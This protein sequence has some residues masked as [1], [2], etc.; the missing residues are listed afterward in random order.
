MNST[1][2][3]RILIANRGEIA[4]RVVR[5]AR[6]RGLQSVAAYSEADAGALHVRLAD[7][8]VPIGPA[9]VAQSYLSIDA[10]LAAA[11]AS[12]ADAVHPGYGFLSENAE[13]A[14]ACR[15]ARLVFIGPSPEAI[16]AMGNKAAAKRRMLEAGM[17]CVPGYQGKEQDDATFAREAGRIGYP[18]MV[19][20][21]AGGG[22]RGMRLV[23]QSADL[24]Q[25]LAS[26]RSEAASAFGSDELIL[27]KA[28]L[29]PR[30]VEIQILAD[31]HGN[32]VHVGER[33]CSVQ[34]RH[35]KVLEEAPCPVMTETLR[36][37]MGRAAVEAARAI[38][39]EGA[40]TVEF[41]L[42][43]RGDFFFLEMNTRI[44]VEHPVTE[45]VSGLDLV[46]LQID[47]AQGKPLPF[48]QADIRLEGHAIE[49][50][51][52]A[53]DPAA[54]FLP[55]TGKILRW[56]PPS[57]PGIRVDH[58]LAEHAEI[59]PFYDPMIAKLIAYGATRDEARRRLIRA[60]DETVLF[61]VATNRGFLRAMLAHPAF[62]AGEATTAF[63]AEHFSRIEPMDDDRLAA[64]HAVAAVLLA[65]DGSFG[66]LSSWWSTGQA[67]SLIRLRRGADDRWVEV[68][69]DGPRF[70]V[71]DGAD[72]REFRVTER[73]DG[74][75][76][77][78][79]EKVGYRIDFARDGNL[80]ELALGDDVFR[81]EDI[82]YEP[83]ETVQPGAD[84]VVRAPMNGTVVLVNA[85]AGAKVSKGEALAVIE[86]MKMEHRILAP[87]DATVD[88]VTVAKG[89]Q[90]ANRQILMTLTAN[91]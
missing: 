21:A 46:G 86:A 41:L 74:F 27:E 57:G 64:A 45:M 29:G 73:G 76:G 43:A 91:T 2:F 63:I 16:S 47:I 34:R 56:T 54:G 53:E 17:P 69:A 11:R 39:Y 75:V 9:L 44:Q 42:D 61:G 71:R 55:Q 78:Q 1:P 79:H 3:Q 15:D 52:Y 82:S 60:L 28:I 65:S 66:E 58:G 25:A 62:A 59:S 37:A 48:T 67:A 88:M 77:L 89:D 87:V 51:L 50:R 84:G 13:F 5:A 85:V 7:M 31:R 49:A 19:K 26:A 33:D 68:R 10:I 80:V 36:A 23:E 4:C 6:G 32:V 70:I 24:A 30:H 35:Q 14:S 83:A 8:A 22:G 81:F 90:V 20:A 38:A 12:G 72:V 18:V 40:G